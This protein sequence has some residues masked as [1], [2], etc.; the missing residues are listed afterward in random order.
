M[1]YIVTKHFKGDLLIRYVVGEV[2]WWS[3]ST[4][5]A[6]YVPIWGVSLLADGFMP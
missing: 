5:A 2:R 1:F 4:A 3:A 6:S